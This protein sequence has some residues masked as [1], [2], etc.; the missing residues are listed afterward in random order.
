MTFAGWY[1]G[2]GYY[3]KIDHGNGLVTTYAHLDSI[4]VVV[5]QKVSNGQQIGRVGNSGRSTGPHLHFEVYLNGEKVN[6]GKYINP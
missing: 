2:Y 6:P 1:S 3:V 4:A 5:G